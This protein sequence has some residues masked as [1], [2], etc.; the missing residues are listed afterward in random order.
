[1]RKLGL[2][3]NQLA[4]FLPNDEA[5][6]AFERLFDFQSVSPSTIEEAAALAGTAAAI[7]NQALTL[8]AGYSVL[9]DQLRAAP[10][11]VIAPEPDDF[12]PPTVPTPT[13]TLGEQ[14]ANHV[15]ITGGAI[16]DTPI[17]A[18][19][20]A[21]GAFTTLAASLLMDLSE[22]TAGQIKFPT[23]QNASADPNTLDDYEEG[24][25]TPAVTGTTAAGVGTYSLR[26]GSYVKIG[27]LVSFNLLIAWTAHTG[28]GNLTITGLPFASAG[29]APPCSITTS[30]L[31]FAGQ[32]AAYVNGA[33][34]SLMQLATNAPIS[35]VPMD[36]TSTELRISGQFFV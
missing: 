1:M 35:A 12:T 15:V 28:T 20:Q 7:A 8:L 24:T 32:V 36:P 16:D 18:T 4:K 21:S 5:I 30:D 34:I 29:N 23:T 17:G 27:R 22:P 19:T 9:L 13:G 2:N 10:A 6:K 25:F 3:R 31:S 26:A 11:A 14:D 33:V